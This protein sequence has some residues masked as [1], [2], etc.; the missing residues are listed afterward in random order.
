M[1]TFSA[2]DSARLRN[3]RQLLG[4]PLRGLTPEMLSAQLDSF[5][6]GDLRA[7]AQTWDVMERR[8]PM[9]GSVA[10]KRYRSVS[11]LD[12]Q[13]KVAEDSPEAEAH[14]AVL[15][16]FWRSVTVT[17]ALDRNRRGGVATL[18]RQ[19]AAAIGHR[20]A[21]HEIVW[22]PEPGRLTA[23]FTRVPLWFFECRTGELRYLTADYGIAGTPLEPGGWLV[24]CGDGIME[25]TCALVAWCGLGLGDWLAYS[26]K[27][28]IPGML[29]ETTAMPGSP[30]WVAAEGA[31]ASFSADWAAVVAAGT[32]VT[33]INSPT[34]SQVIPQGLVEYLERRIVTL[35]RGADLGTMSQ[36]GE[37]VG[38]SLQGDESRILM[39]DDAE[40]ITEPLRDQVERH[41]IEWHFGPGV[42]P[43]AYLDLVLP[44][45]P[46]TQTD[47][48][49][50]KQLVE[51]GVR[52]SSTDAAERYGR[53]IASDDED[54]LIVPVAAPAPM[55]AP[56]IPFRPLLANEATSTGRAATPI[57]LVAA[58]LGD[59][60]A[61]IRERIESISTIDDPVRRYEALM[62]LKLDLPA[63]LSQA[64]GDLRVARAFER[65]LGDSLT[66]GLLSGATA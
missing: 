49:V 51:Q 29:W 7:A 50:D 53:K 31:A 37:G 28:A 19:S 64:T 33:P 47:L 25:A 20:W 48:M 14:Q 12:W 62:S 23:T 42:R 44:S 6:A 57:D 1:K 27:F 18:L 54:V 21:V 61:P 11:R 56:G 63:Y 26:E 41:V 13:V 5:A 65:V 52:L 15:E 38:A 16:E 60:F 46:A 55:P 4:N 36:G 17:D 22:R 9:L 34:G 66:R 32:K 30:E 8:H 45:Q 35:W 40:D 3:H 39:E 2:L 10:R 59:K 43:L 24:H 58:A